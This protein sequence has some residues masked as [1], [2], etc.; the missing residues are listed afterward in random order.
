[1]C[2]HVDEQNK[3]HF[4]STN[5]HTLNQ[6]STLPQYVTVDALTKGMHSFNPSLLREHWI[7]FS[8]LGRSLFSPKKCFHP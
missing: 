8:N 4:Y 3:N 2:D 1:M 7:S 6:Q 5:K